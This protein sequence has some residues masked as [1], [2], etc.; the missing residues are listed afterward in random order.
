MLDFLGAKTADSPEVAKASPM[1]YV[2]RL[3]PPILTFHGTLDPVVPFHQAE[4]LHAAL[5]K[6]GVDEKL[7]PIP[8]GL[9]GG[10]SQ[11]AKADADAEARTFFDQYLKGDPT[12]RAIDPEPQ[13]NA[14]AQT[15]KAGVLH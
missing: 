5:K 1:T 12:A 2:S 8:N 15:D 6:V 3:C 9:H 11:T 13:R 10:W 14:T 4:L 7:V